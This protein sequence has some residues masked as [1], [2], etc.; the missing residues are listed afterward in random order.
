MAKNRPIRASD[1]PEFIGQMI[2]VFEDFLEERDIELSNEDRAQDPDAAIIYGD[3][4]DT[5]QSGI[6]SILKN[7][8]LC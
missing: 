3:D 7:W 2:D 1:L 4:Y 6:E 5:L 8:K